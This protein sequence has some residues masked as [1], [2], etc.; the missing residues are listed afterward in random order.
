VRGRDREGNR[1]GNRESERESKSHEA[2]MGKSVRDVTYS[3]H[4]VEYL[5]LRL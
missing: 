2:K 3:S 5:W 4:V 1:E